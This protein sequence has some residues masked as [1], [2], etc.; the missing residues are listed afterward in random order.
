MSHKI[1]QCAIRTASSYISESS[2]LY[3]NRRHSFTPI[4]LRGV[5]GRDGPTVR[6]QTTV[7]IKFQIKNSWTE[8]FSIICGIVPDGTFPTEL[9][10]GRKVIHKLGIYYIINSENIQLLALDGK[11]TLYP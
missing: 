8:V 11:P 4:K 5:G 7:E 1:F 10:L 3:T 6:E 9:T 2:A